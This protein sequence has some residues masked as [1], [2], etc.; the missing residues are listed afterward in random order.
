MIHTETPMRDASP[1]RP[2]D[3]PRGEPPCLC[4][5]LMQCVRVRRHAVRDG[6]LVYLSGTRLDEVHLV[7]SGVFKVTMVTRD[8]REKLLALRFSG[9]WL[10]FDGIA[11]GR[12][13]CD[14]AALE[15]G[16]L[17]SVRYDELL[18]ACVR[19]ADLASLMHRAMSDEIARDRA[20]MKSLCTL[21]A[22]ARVASFLG[23]WV[24][25]LALRGARTDRINLRLTREEIGNYLGL[26]LESVSRAFT[27]LAR[28][29]VIGFAEPTHREVE[30]RDADALARFVPRAVLEA[31]R[32]VPC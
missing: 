8:G 10:G 3:M 31:N 23:H 32:L 28:E 2:A 19:N 25:T 27:H 16:E 20:S 21:S 1:P 14:A 9:E 13:V 18:R 15:A 29:G 7:R 11:E 24:D 30:I 12:H 26:R 6:A 4:D 5:L 17:W 22:D